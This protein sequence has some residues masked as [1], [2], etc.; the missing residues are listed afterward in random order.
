MKRVL[1]LITI[2]L[3]AA[4]CLYN[5]NIPEIEEA[6]NAMVFDGNIVIG[7]KATLSVFR[8]T[9]VNAKT[10]GATVKPTSW[11]VEDETGASYEAG[12]SASV[13]LTGAPTDRA[14]RI[15]AE[16]DGKTYSS[17]FQKPLPAPGIESL[18]FS[19][20]D[21]SVSCNISF[22]LDPSQG[23]YVALSFEEIWEFHAD[24][25]R[26]FDVDTVSWAVTEL[27]YA[28]LSHYYCWTH[29]KA[30]LSAMVDLGSLDGKAVDYVVNLFPTTN[31]RNHRNY[32]L[33]VWA[34]SINE[35]EY[36]F[37]STLAGQDG[38][39]NLFTPNPGEIAGNVVCDDDPSEYVY[40]YVSTSVSTSIEK[41]L[42]DRY[43]RKTNPNTASLITIEPGS[44]QTF[45]TAGYWPVVSE[46]NEYKWGL[47]R[48]VDCVLA[49]GT[50][51]K[52]EF[53]D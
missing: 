22:S 24:F 28:D 42:D 9:P 26:V 33:K 8:L 2:L 38:G 53:S 44:I 14:Y 1:P 12:T 46:D 51:E 5:Y 29:R 3:A 36:R 7:N 32:Y 49:G 30:E 50:L 17:Q 27:D 37:Q 13:D 35:Q 43:L 25:V 52:P 15:V 4:S 34:R 31:S 45:Y 39:L 18:T 6:E 48:C 41:H 20:D 23:R 40:G 19:A 11:R 16:C 47:K 21:A 10:S